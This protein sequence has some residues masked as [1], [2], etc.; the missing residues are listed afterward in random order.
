MSSK[1][2]R[3]GITVALV[4]G[5]AATVPAVGSAHAAPAGNWKVAKIATYGSLENLGFDGTGRMLL[6]ADTVDTRTPSGRKGVLVTGV[7]S[8]GGISVR[9]G[10]AYY[11]AGNAFASGAL[12]LRDGSIGSVDLKTGAK[13]TVATGL[14]MP[15]GLTALPS[16]GFVVSRTLG[17]TTGLTLVR[18][19]GT[20]KAI[21]KGLTSTNGVWWDATRKRV[22]T[23]TSA[24]AATTVAAVNPST[25][26]WRTLA[27]VP[28]V[29]ALNFADDLTTDADGNIYVA[30]DV[31]GK[32]L[33]IDAATGRQHVIA[34]V[35]LVTSV[36]FGQGPGWDSAS[37]YATSLTG[38]LYKLTPR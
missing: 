38:G 14:T 24:N 21:A 27:T 5:V 7:T 31:A 11:A 23:A 20:T 4:A 37:L 36:R 33:R 12:G 6:S 25:G 2:I 29:S 9:D 15:N 10:K 26:A 19:N 35:P 13:R 22:L 8:P 18:E 17:A 32:V 28:G 30:L 16:G 3:R 1:N 34:Q